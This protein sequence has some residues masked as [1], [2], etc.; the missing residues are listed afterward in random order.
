MQLLENNQWW[1]GVSVPILELIVF[2]KWFIPIL[3]VSMSLLSRL[4]TLIRLFIIMHPE[5]WFPQ[6]VIPRFPR[7]VFHRSS[8]LHFFKLPVLIQIIQ[9]FLICCVVLMFI[10]GMMTDFPTMTAAVGKLSHGGPA[11]G[12]GFGMTFYQ[13]LK[14]AS[15]TAL[16]NFIIGWLNGH[17][18]TC[19]CPPWFGSPIPVPVVLVSYCWQ[20]LSSAPE[21]FK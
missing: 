10:P 11:W 17:G 15:P 9:I 7:L 20:G 19:T 8:I 12:Q 13:R 21:T 5:S 16:N 1:S 18:Q 4:G 6:W 2:L 3:S 14:K